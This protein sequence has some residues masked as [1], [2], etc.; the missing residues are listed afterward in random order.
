MEPLDPSMVVF[1]TNNA[2]VPDPRAVPDPSTL[3]K[4]FVLDPASKSDKTKKDLE[5][6]G[7]KA[8]KTLRSPYDPLFDEE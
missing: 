2:P 4:H 1:N 3:N 7:G 5:K 6:K 8:K